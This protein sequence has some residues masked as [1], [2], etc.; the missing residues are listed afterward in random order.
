MSSGSRAWRWATLPKPSPL[1]TDMAVVPGDHLPAPRTGVLRV[2]S[3][4]VV[5]SGDMSLT[6]LSHAP[7]APVGA[8]KTLDT[9]LG[10]LCTVGDLLERGSQAY[11]LRCPISYRGTARPLVAGYPG[12]EHIPGRVQSL[13]AQPQSRPPLESQPPATCDAPQFR[14]LMPSRRAAGRLSAPPAVFTR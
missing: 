1:F 14:G 3:G 13:S 11:Q 8:Q 2:T 5:N 7:P 4:Q 10:F 6:W 12:P 9:P